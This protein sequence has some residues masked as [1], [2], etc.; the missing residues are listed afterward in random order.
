MLSKQ[1]SGNLFVG[2]LPV[3]ITGVIL[4]L[5][6]CGGGDSGNAGTPTG[7]NGGNTGGA[8]DTGGPPSNDTP[9]TPTNGTPG[10]HLFYYS[11]GIVY[12]I[13]TNEPTNPVSVSPARRSGY[14][15]YQGSYNAT[16]HSLD[17]L[18]PNAA[19]WLANAPN[20]NDA[21][22]FDGVIYKA[23]A[24]RP[25][26][27][28]TTV[29]S[30]SFTYTNP[31]TKRSSDFCGMELV[32]DWANPEAS[33]LF[34]WLAGSNLSCNSYVESDDT[35]HMVRLD[36]DETTAPVSVPADYM[37][38]LRDPETGAIAG[39][40]VHQGSAFYQASATFAFDLNS[41]IQDAS[42]WSQLL[43]STP[44]GEYLILKQTAAEIAIEKYSMNTN[45][46][47]GPV[48]SQSK[49][50]SSTTYLYRWVSDGANLYF[51]VKDSVSGLTL[52]R[53]PFS[54]TGLNEAQPMAMEAAGNIGLFTVSDTAVFY[55][56]QDAGSPSSPATLKIVAKTAAS[57]E[58]GLAIDPPEAVTQFDSNA[59]A[60]LYYNSVGADGTYYAS[61]IA[62][63]GNYIARY[64]NAAWRGSVRTQISLYSQTHTTNQIL[65]SNIAAGGGFAGASLSLFDATSL[66]PTVSLGVLDEDIVGMNNVNSFGNDV[67]AAITV[68]A[69]PSNSDLL[70]FNIANADSVQRL[71]R[72]S[73]VTEAVFKL[74][75]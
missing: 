5:P 75:E 51:F 16:T 43:A 56:W 49:N 41:Q 66:Q 67:L 58:P 63:N 35:M 39:W 62:D 61:I 59:V 23:S 1:K 47:L 60:A 45:T 73:D 55:A 17:S 28:A 50:V 22:R 15:V 13:N 11:S 7:D 31:T 12:A 72:S 53:L 10:D 44:S 52:Y 21:F 71:T 46:N 70:F 6:A 69:T 36:Y 26:D 29:S 34:Y 27:G 9:P 48:F 19:V 68:G 8:P 74:A 20:S 30:G 33:Q 14:V 65:V 37:G 4:L 3:L 64:D 32:A 42:G 38:P 18:K 40:I 54:A 24:Q 2:M 25:F 57:T